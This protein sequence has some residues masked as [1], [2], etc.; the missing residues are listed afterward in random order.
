MTANALR[1]RVFVLRYPSRLMEAGDDLIQ[2]KQIAQAMIT[3][4]ENDLN[5]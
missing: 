5:L 3:K 4:A 1:E 2:V